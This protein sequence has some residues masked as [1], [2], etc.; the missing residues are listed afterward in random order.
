MITFNFTV[1]NAFLSYMRRPI[2][3]PSGEVDYELLEAEKLCAKD[4]T[5]ICP[6]GERMSGYM[7]S[8]HSSWRFYY[9]IIIRGHQ[10]DPLGRLPFR[11]RLI[12]E[13]ERLGSEVQVRLN[14][15]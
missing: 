4:L 8:S 2:T 3:V 10:N 14:T 15:K 11:Q 5:V 12:V 13:I 1:K 7:Y 6:N 9:Q